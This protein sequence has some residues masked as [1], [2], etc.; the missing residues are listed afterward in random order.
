M[1]NCPTCKEI[2]R[3]LSGALVSSFVKKQHEAIL[4]ALRLAREGGDGWIRVDDKLPE[5]EGMYLCRFTDGATETFPFTEE[6][7]DKPW[8]V[9]QELV[10]HWQY[11]PDPS[12]D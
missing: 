5:N 4:E 2:Q 6:D 8:G 12:H 1:N 7:R 11:L 9:H 3:V 10:T